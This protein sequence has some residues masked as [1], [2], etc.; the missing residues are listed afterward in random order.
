VK[1]D[2]RL[3]AATNRDLDHMVQEGLFRKDL[4]FRIRGIVIDLPP[5]RERME[6]MNELVISC[7]NKFCMNHGMDRK[8]YSP[9]F[10]DAL[11]SYNWP[12]NVREL[13]HTLESALTVARDEP[14]LFPKHLPIQVRVQM[15]KSQIESNQ[16]ESAPEYPNSPRDSEGRFLSY[17]EFRESTL[18]E[19][20]RKY[21]LALLAF[22]KGSIKEACRLSGLSRTQLYNLLKRHQISRSELPSTLL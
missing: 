16:A 22:A 6:D 12:G 10:L 4:L 13:L 5:L 17:R 7:L 15:V 2:F 20:E 18:L 21:L 1:S 3:I 11:T 14:I 9:D 8:G 19:P